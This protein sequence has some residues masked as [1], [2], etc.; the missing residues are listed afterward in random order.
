LEGGGEFQW[1]GKR[2]VWGGVKKERKIRFRSFLSERRS[3]EPTRK[4][5]GGGDFLN[6]RGRENWV[7]KGQS[8]PRQA[9]NL[10]NE[11]RQRR[12]GG[13]QFPEKGGGKFAG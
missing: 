10:W 12:E 5:M 9:C 2:E 13:K 4:E 11:E 7:K 3:S 1:E 6:G 8:A